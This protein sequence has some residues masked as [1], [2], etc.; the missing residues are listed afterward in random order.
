M[1][2]QIE[3]N[4]PRLFT[5]RAVISSFDVVHPKDFYF[6]GEMHNFWEMVFVVDG[7]AGITADE[8]VYTLEKG[9]LIFHKPMEFHRIWSTGGT[10]THLYIMAFDV[11]G[12]GLKIFEN[13]VLY[14]ENSD[15][16][17][18]AD[19][20]KEG[21][22]ILKLEEEGLSGGTGQYA[23]AAHTTSAK[24]ELFLLKLMK[25]NSADTMPRQSTASILYRQI[26]QVLDEHWNQNLSITEVAGLCNLS[27]SNLKKI[28]HRFSD[29]GIMKYF[30][31]IKIRKAISLLEEGLTIA[32]I[33][34]RLSF[35]SQNYFTVVFRRET[36]M[37]PSQYRKKVGCGD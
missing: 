5:V 37:T 29:K 32:E 8:R 15:E 22:N 18:L 14:L 30:M 26:V 35:S 11:S 20:I 36:G 25:K 21:G 33:S 2:Q 34:D 6:S 23:L 7:K 19:C 12:E 27:V 24:I 13:R 31:Y 16:E 10:E 4:L 9:Q 3:M 1:L 17:Y 28:F